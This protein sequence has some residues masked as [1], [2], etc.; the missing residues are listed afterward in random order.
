MKVHL[1]A[2]HYVM[3]VLRAEKKC[4]PPLEKK[5]VHQ[6]DKTSY[7]AFSHCINTYDTPCITCTFVLCV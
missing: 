7:V 3:R 2:Y 1:P 6:G 4:L 5:P